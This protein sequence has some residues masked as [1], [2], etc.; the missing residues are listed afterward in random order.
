MCAFTFNVCRYDEGCVTQRNCTGGS[1]LVVLLATGRTAGRNLV[2]AGMFDGS[3]QTWDVSTGSPLPGGCI[4]SR[5]ILAALA[6]DGDRVA[7]VA[8]NTRGFG[9]G[10]MVGALYTLNPVESS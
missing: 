10:G 3:I 7:F 5:G 1:S 9:G 6:T 8:R 4:A 2:T